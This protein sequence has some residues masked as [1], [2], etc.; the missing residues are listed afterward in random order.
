MRVGQTSVRGPGADQPRG[1]RKLST[2]LTMHNERNSFEAI[3]SRGG[4]GGS[5]FADAACSNRV[6]NAWK[7]T[8]GRRQRARAK[9]KHVA[10]AAVAC[11]R[12]VSRALSLS[13]RTER[14]PRLVYVLGAKE[15]VANGTKET[16]MTRSVGGMGGER[17][18]SRSFCTQTLEKRARTHTRASLGTTAAAAVMG[19]WVGGGGDTA[20]D[21]LVT[22]LHGD[23]S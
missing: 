2:A 16:S 19:R 11:L 17:I 23:M 18:V 15:P 7:L 6:V 3:C 8:D 9:R 21:R 4:G 13:R 12:K 1:P 22:R 14:K 10:A 20:A 5:S